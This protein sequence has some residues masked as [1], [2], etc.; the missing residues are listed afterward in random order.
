MNTNGRH[1]RAVA[2]AIALAFVSVACGQTAPV[3]APQPLSS[4]K[5]A[6]TE[7]YR[8][9]T[10]CFDRILTTGDKKQFDVL[11]TGVLISPDGHH[12]FLVTAK[13]IWDEP[14]QSWHPSE[15]RLRFSIK[16]QKPSTEELGSAIRLADK[17]GKNLWMAPPDGSDIAAISLTSN[18]QALVI[19]AIGFQGFAQSDDVFDG[20]AGFVFGYPGDTRPLIGPN[21]LVRAVTRSGIIAW[22]DPNGALDNPLL[23]DSNI[24]PG[25]SGGPAFKVPTGLDKYGTFNVG[26][27]VAM[28]GTGPAAPKATLEPHP[29]G[30]A[31]I[32]YA[33]ADVAAAESIVT[34]L[35]NNGVRCWIAPRDVKAG[36][37]YSDVIVR[38]ISDA[39]ALVLVL[40]ENSV[41]EE[42]ASNLPGWTPQ[43]LIAWRNNERVMSL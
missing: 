11:G 30:A 43:R 25:N 20:G 19:D 29:A 6:W 41:A 15:L 26:N 10:V 2:I 28:D 38:A 27:R 16:E 32:S 18:F 14:S 34:T 17:Q 22:T 33:S 40:S 12:V 13:H 36:A 31:F 8:R 24:L 42:V 5:Q 39:K 35:E 7:H 23:L 37:L 21:G 9:A 3:P 4:N 1:G